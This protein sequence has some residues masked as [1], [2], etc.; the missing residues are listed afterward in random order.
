MFRILCNMT[1]TVLFRSAFGSTL[2]YISLN[3]Y[4]F[5]PTES[6]DNKIVLFSRRFS[7]IL[8]KL[9]IWTSLSDILIKHRNVRIAKFEYKTCTKR[10]SWTIQ[11]LSLENQKK[12]QLSFKSKYILVSI[13]AVPRKW[14]SDDWLVQCAMKIVYSTCCRGTIWKN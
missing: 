1:V 3:V 13:Q 8:L 5:K 9:C 6:G 2:R 14:E 11:G 10:K 7:M 4:R 12:H